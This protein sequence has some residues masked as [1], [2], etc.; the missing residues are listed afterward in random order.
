MNTVKG[1]YRYVRTNRW[2]HCTCTTY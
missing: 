2:W 1:Y